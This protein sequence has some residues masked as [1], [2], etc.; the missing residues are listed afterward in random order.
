MLYF[1]WAGVGP[2]YF[3]FLNYLQIFILFAAQSL[4]SWQISQKVKIGTMFTHTHK[5]K[6]EWKNNLSNINI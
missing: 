4:K 6:K 2:T 5:K 1:G 3:V